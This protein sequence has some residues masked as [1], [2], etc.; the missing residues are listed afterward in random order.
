M[1]DISHNPPG[2]AE[3]LGRT[4]LARCLAGL[5]RT[6]PELRAIRAGENRI[7]DDGCSEIVMK[8]REHQYVRHFD[9]ILTQF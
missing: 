6:S 8:L 3:G 2:P 9:A 1:V 4:Q 5:I 7:G